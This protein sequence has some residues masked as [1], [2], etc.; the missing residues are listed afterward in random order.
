MKKSDKMFSVNINSTGEQPV[1]T[2]SGVANLVRDLL[3]KSEAGK[4]INI[5]IKVTAV[6]T[7]S[8]ASETPS[9]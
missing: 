6:P 2:R 1:N 5:T 3:G 7:E 9:S 4:D 8:P